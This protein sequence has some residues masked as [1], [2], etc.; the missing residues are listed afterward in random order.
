MSNLLGE[1]KKLLLMALVV[2]V[3]MIVMYVGTMPVRQLRR[4]LP[5]AIYAGIALVVLAGIVVA[6]LVAR[7]AAAQLAR[8]EINQAVASGE[9]WLLLRPKEAKPVDVEKVA[10][11]K[12]LAYA[13]PTQEHFAFEVFGNAD[14][15]GLAIHASQTKTRS[16]LREF[17]QEWPDAQRRLLG[18]DDK[19]PDP[20]SV[21][22]GWHV[23]WLEVGPSSTDQ[24]VTFSARDPLLAILAELN[25]IADPTRGLVQVIA[26]SDTGTRRRLGTQS[27]A[28]RSG[29]AQDPG[30]RYQ[31][32]KEAKILE[33][34]GSRLFLEV[35][36][37][38]SAISPDPDRAKGAATALANTLCNQFGPENPVIVL[39]QAK[40]KQA[41][42]NLA[43]RTLDGGAVRSWADDE[44][45]GLAHLPGSDAIQAAPMLST[46]SATALPAKPELRVPKGA[47]VAQYEEKI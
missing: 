46:G 9:S 18:K 35:V 31:Q 7:R 20:A 40:P 22:E 38:V 24:P 28:I 39:V 33:E 47:R 23:Y 5:Y 6:V 1:S 36:V 14:K 11:W 3:I 15:Q 27:A 12:R 10:L 29:A 45:V 13:Q 2:I 4:L 41:P 19:T 32:T 30:A 17:T 16:V 34:R 21:P 26:R 8:D 43:A 44:L 25:D 37:R 42:P